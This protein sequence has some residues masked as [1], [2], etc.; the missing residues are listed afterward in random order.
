VTPVKNT[1]NNYHL[2]VLAQMDNSMLVMANAKIVT[3][4]ARLVKRVLAIVLF[5]PKTERMIHQNAHAQTAPL[6]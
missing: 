6:K 3:K 5:A 2:T 1:E 4:N